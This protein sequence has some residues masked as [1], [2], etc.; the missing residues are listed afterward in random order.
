MAGDVSATRR[1]RTRAEDRALCLHEAAH[2][3]TAEH[4][5]PGIVMGI[6]MDVL[7]GVP[8][9]FWGA[10]YADDTQ[11][12]C[13][14]TSLWDY[15][16]SLH[17]IAIAA[18]REGERIDPD[19]DWRYDG[20]DAAILRAACRNPLLRRKARRAAA[21]IVRDNE[22]AVRRV[23]KAAAEHRVLDGDEIRRLIAR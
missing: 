4:V 14:W 5:R 18:G 13:T 2:A 22:L 6:E 1:R 10:V 9:H 17:W 3:V 15:D 7:P 16:D 20:G 21:K 8:T 19:P 12:H 11:A 23:A